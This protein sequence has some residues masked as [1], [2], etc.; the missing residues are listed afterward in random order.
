[1]IAMQYDFQLPADYDMEVIDQRVRDKGHVFDDTPGLGVKA[2]L[3]AR[4]SPDTGSP[5]NLYAPF[6]VWTDPSAMTDFLCGERFAG[7]VNAFGW[8][9]VRSWSVLGTRARSASAL[10]TAARATRRIDPVRPYESLAQ[11]RATEQAALDDA[12]RAGALLAVAGLD[13]RSWERVRFCLWDELPPSSAETTRY[14]VLH[15]SAPEG[16]A[17]G[18]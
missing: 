1:M 16:D 8:P 12:M 18:G 10:K 11:Y 9:Q 2:F 5:V 14:A 7:L 4:R 3:S 13:A 6:Y 17:L 15:T